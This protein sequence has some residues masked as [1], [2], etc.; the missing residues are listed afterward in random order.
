MIKK[1][2]LEKCVDA[3]KLE[4]NDV[5]VFIMVHGYQGNNFDMRL[6]KDNLALKYPNL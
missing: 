5:H 6:F 4:G 1:N 2:T 3:S